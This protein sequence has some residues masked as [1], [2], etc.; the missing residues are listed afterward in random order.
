MG[1]WWVNVSATAIIFVMYIPSLNYYLLVKFCLQCP[2]L[3]QGFGG[4]W[5]IYM[6]RFVLLFS[7]IIPIRYYLLYYRFGAF[8]LP[9]MRFQ[10]FDHCWF[11]FL[12]ILIVLFVCWVLCFAINKLTGYHFSA[13]IVSNFDTDVRNVT[14]HSMWFPLVSVRL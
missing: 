14:E 3:F 8:L 4:P 12:P 11:C 1:N 6:F 7:Y 2:L 5:Y 9:L 13:V 10:R